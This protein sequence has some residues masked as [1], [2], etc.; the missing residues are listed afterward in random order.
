MIVKG[1]NSNHPVERLLK[2]KVKL[3]SFAR[4]P[5]NRTLCQTN[6]NEFEYK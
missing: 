2:M 6:D 4:E 1:N 5:F 3:A